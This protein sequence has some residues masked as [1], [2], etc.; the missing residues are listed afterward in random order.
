MEKQGFK[1]QAMA[2]TS[3]P[4]HKFELAIALHD[5]KAA[6]ALAT[7]IGGE[8]KWRQLGDL[9]MLKCDLDL[10]S[11]CMQNAQ[12]YGGVLLLASATG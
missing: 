2:V 8:Q 9:A 1:A 11:K 3:D 5:V 7:E 6:L 12:D 10:A 4:E